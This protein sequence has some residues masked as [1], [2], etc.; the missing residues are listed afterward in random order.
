MNFW[1]LIQ[2]HDVSTATPAESKSSSPTSGVPKGNGM[3]HSRNNSLLPC[4]VPQYRCSLLA[5]RREMPTAFESLKNRAN[6]KNWQGR[7]FAHLFCVRETVPIITY[8]DIDSDPTKALRPAIDSFG[9]VSF[10][11]TEYGSF[12]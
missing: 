9:K 6:V 2:V 10:L 11:P 5:S 3:P 7:Q 4:F 1:R 8:S 12:P